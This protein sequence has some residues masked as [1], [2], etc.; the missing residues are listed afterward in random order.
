MSQATS[1]LIQATSPLSVLTSMSANGSS[2]RDTDGSDNESN[3]VGD[4]ADVDDGNDVDPLLMA[5]DWEDAK[6]Q[7]TCSEDER[8]S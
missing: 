3:H 2:R 4:A 5:A 7:K 1:V 6:M 8:K